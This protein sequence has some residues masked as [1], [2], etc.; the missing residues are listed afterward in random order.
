MKIAID[1]RTAGGEKTGKGWFTFHIT[2]NLLKLDRENQYILYVKDKIPGFDDFK[3]AKIK[4]IKGRSIFWHRNVA[5]DVKK[6]NVDIFFAPSSYIIPALLPKSISTVLTIHDLVAFLFPE[7]HNKKITLIEKLFLKKAL[8]KA[9]H[10]ITVSNNTK[11]DVLEK[12]KFYK[13]QIS[14]IYNAA[15]EVY[16]PVPKES[17]TSFIKKTNLPQN[18]FIAVGTLIPR[19]NYLNLIRA[20]ALLNKIHP[21]TLSGSYHLIIVGGKGWED[22]EIINEIRTNYLNKK[23]HLLGYLSTTSIRNLYNLAKALVFPSFYEGFG[24]PPLEAMKCGCPVIASFSSS[25]PEVVGD[26]A[27]LINPESPEEIAI[28][29][30]KIVENEDLAET[31]RNKGFVQS[32]KFSWTNSAEKL[33]QIFHN[34]K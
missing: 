21:R 34:L 20:L 13:N 19:K 31:L 23:V 33:L 27:L 22:K 7:T 4:Q 9:D 29:M 30:K 15:N 26:A 1:I 8:K 14:I 5:K 10:V 32:K 17:L 12:F 16:K 25:I 18:F 2:R 24:I 28:S 11:K 6:E 3:N